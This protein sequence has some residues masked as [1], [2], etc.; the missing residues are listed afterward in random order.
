MQCPASVLL[1]SCNCRLHCL[2]IVLDIK[3]CLWLAMNIWI[4]STCEPIL[5]IIVLTKD[6]IVCVV[7]ILYIYLVVITISEKW[8]YISSF[9]YLWI[10]SNLIMKEL[11]RCFECWS[12]TIIYQLKKQQMLKKRKQAL[13]IKKWKTM[14]DFQSTLPLSTTFCF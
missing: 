7:D 3:V 5:K 2:Q 14:Y 8:N 1:E 11:F 9:S 10:Q 13:A 4:S 12:S 6:I